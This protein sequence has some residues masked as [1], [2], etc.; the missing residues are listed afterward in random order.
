M[1][2]I[3]CS[4]I[5]DDIKHTQLMQKLEMAGFSVLD[6]DLKLSD[7][8]FK[9]TGI[10]ESPFVEELS[11]GYIK[12]VDKVDLDSGNHNIKQI[13]NSSHKCNF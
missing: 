10:E 4:L 7:T 11:K 8:I 2:E 3:I 13:L 5:E 9:L 1:K 6:H 12:I